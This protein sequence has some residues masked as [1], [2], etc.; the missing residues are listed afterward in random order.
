[1]EVLVTMHL[2]EI[3]SEKGLSCEQIAIRAGISK[4]YVND[5]ENNRRNPTLNVLCRL[6]LALDVSPC[7]LFS[8]KK[9]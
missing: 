6:S 1:M 9:L 3:R 8:F 4:S 7:D 2:G 5:I